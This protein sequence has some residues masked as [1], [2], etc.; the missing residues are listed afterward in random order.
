[1]TYILL[2]ALVP[3]FFLVLGN[4]IAMVRTPGE[5][6]ES[7]FQHFAAGVVFS[8]VALELLPRLRETQD[9]LAA[10]LGFIAGV[11]VML[12]IERYAENAGFAVPVAVDLFI[13]GMLV[14]IGFVAGREG[15][16]LL[17]AG[18]SM[19]TF[20]LGLSMAPMMIKKG[21]SKLRTIMLAVGLGLAILV[22]AGAGY[23]AS[24]ISGPGLT[25][26]LGFG[27][28][29]LLYLV[30]EELLAQAHKRE[31]TPIVTASFFAGFLIPF[32]ISYIR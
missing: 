1:M 12:L 19:E 6:L 17:L 7:L 26:I 21:V 13:D 14:A 27:V 24:G 2:F 25:A 15:G 28:A 18:L 20:S 4:L 31:D 23:A 30:T 8:A 10:A 22:G 9:P 3:A 32:L 5:S 11:I 16:F 29:A